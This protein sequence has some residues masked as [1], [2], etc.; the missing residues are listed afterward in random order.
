[1]GQD[2]RSVFMNNAAGSWPKAPGVVEAVNS[3]LSRR[4][5]HPGRTSLQ[6]DDLAGRCRE[7][8]AGIMGVEDKTRVAITFNATHSLNIAIM[9]MGL[10]RGDVVVTTV[11]EHNSV[12]RPLAH[13]AERQ[14]VEVIEIGLDDNNLLDFAAFC[15]ALERRPKLVAINHASNVT[16]RIQDAARYFAAAKKAGAVTLLDASQTMGHARVNPDELFADMVAF[17]G[18][19]GLLGPPGIGGL[20]VRPGIELE[21][22]MVGGTGVRSDLTL[23][24]ED[25]PTRLEA[26]TPNV[27]AMAGL[28]LALEWLQEKGHDF[29]RKEMDLARGLREGLSQIGRVNLMDYDPAAE[30]VGI[31]SFTVEGWEVEEAGYVLQE[32]FGIVC[33]TGLHCAPHIHAP[34]GSAP[35]GTIR[36]SLSG[37]NV[38]R[39][40]E[41]AVQSIKGLAA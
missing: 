3:A 36:L 18:H 4:P 9:G 40:V 20:Y 1:M 38:E 5:E 31:V 7:L 21:Q 32:S 8:L 12:L 41:Y 15:R 34:L 14:G 22:W 37:F 26:G 25:M 28:A 13:L 30:R 35:D 16:G 17:T 6:K 23:H 33:R 11:T 27:P 39:D 2:L 29:A 24:P 10:Q 19:K